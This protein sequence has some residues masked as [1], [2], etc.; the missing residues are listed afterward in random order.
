MEAN[1][2]NDPLRKGLD[3][4]PR[5]AGVAWLAR[6]RFRNIGQGAAQLRTRPFRWDCR[7]N[8]SGELGALAV[9]EGAYLSERG[10][11]QPQTRC[12]DRKR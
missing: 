3:H 8:A 1:I 2:A 11:M 10:R 7:A 6:H 12:D 5:P 9:Y 4:D